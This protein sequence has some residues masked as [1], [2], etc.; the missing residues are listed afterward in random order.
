MVRRGPTLPEAMAPVGILIV[1]LFLALA[2]VRV[3]FLYALAAGIVSAVALGLRLG[4]DPRELGRM[5]RNGVRP[6]IYILIFLCS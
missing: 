3:S 2:V 4:N 5:M 1:S 6:T